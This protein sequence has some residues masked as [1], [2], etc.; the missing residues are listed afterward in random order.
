M[1]L[2]GALVRAT[3]VARPVWQRRLAS[4]KRLTSAAGAKARAD[5]EQARAEQQ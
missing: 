5:A 2:G 3:L 1:L 4:R